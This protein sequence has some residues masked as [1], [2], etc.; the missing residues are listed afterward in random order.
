LIFAFGRGYTGI[1][2][3]MKM[4]VRDKEDIV[5]EGQQM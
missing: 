4:A 3:N 1:A 2:G 5:N